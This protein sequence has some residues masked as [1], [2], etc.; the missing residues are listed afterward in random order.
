VIHPIVLGTGLRLFPDGVPRTP[1]TLADNAPTTNGVVIAWY[2][3]V[4]G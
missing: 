3:P 1:L 2:R 4:L